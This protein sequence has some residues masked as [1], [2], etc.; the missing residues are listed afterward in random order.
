M[1]KPMNSD[2]ALQKLIWTPCHQQLCD[3]LFKLSQTNCNGEKGS[4][5]IIQQRL[6]CNES[7]NAVTVAISMGPL[8]VQV[9]LNSLW[10]Q[11]E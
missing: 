6:I 10:C 2:A 4:Q 5:P 7:R 11:N 9:K 8:P 3:T 1:A